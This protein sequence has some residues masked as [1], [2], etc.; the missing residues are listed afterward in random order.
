[1][2]RKIEKKDNFFSM[3]IREGEE[4][5]VKAGEDEIVFIAPDNASLNCYIKRNVA[6]LYYKN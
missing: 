1:M 6:P 3:E 4:I 5:R 2:E